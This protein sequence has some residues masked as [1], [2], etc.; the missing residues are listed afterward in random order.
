M[1]YNVEIH[2]SLALERQMDKEEVRHRLMPKKTDIKMIKPIAHYTTL[3]TDTKVLNRIMSQHTVV[4]E[5]MESK[6]VREV[7]HSDIA[8]RHLG[9]PNVYILTFGDNGFITR[10]EIKQGN[11][12]T[13]I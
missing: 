7:G 11:R 9:T 10:V 6:L 2:G 5:V 12:V 3:E 4:V 8:V 13:H 1:A